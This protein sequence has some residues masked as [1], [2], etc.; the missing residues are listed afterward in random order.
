[1]AA[2][3]IP[4]FTRQPLLGTATWTSSSTA[5]AD[6]DGSGTIGT[7]IVLLASADS[8]N[9]SYINRVR[10]HPAATAAATA[11][12]STVIRLFVSTQ[13]SGS[14]TSS[15]T[16]LIAEAAAASVTAASASA[17]AQPIDINLGLALEPGQHLLFSMHHAAASNTLWHA[18]AYGGDY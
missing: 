14:T 13:S 6:S 8:T 15:N 11:T 1:M 3:T 5:N 2:N 9:G 4:I 10:F 16:N 12:T 18:S 17:A 7:D